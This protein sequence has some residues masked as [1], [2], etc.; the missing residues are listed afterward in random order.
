MT[1]CSELMRWVDV[2]HSF[3]DFLLFYFSRWP[4]HIH[5]SRSL[6]SS[7]VCHCRVQSPLHKIIQLLLCQGLLPCYE[8]FFST[9]LAPALPLFVFLVCLL[10]AWRIMMKGQVYTEWGYSDHRVTDVINCWCRR[11]ERRLGRKKIEIFC[12][13]NYWVRAKPYISAGLH[14]D[15][16]LAYYLMCFSFS[17]SCSL[18]L[19]VSNLCNIIH[20]TLCHFLEIPPLIIQR[21]TRELVQSKAHMLTL[22]LLFCH[23]SPSL[24]PCLCLEPLPPSSDRGS[25]KLAGH[26]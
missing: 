6:K 7:C 16:C 4:C 11:R 20:V 17:L 9:L 25:C 12:S 18:R 26:P 1:K 24:V 8:G 19:L 2:S 14:K 10:C 5:Q 23:Y 22:A 21:S 13:L 15:L 3:D